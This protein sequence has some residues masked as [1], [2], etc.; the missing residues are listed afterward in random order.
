MRK[1]FDELTFIDDFM[2]CSVIQNKE[3][4]LETAQRNSL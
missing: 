2:F 4:C 3:I 1:P